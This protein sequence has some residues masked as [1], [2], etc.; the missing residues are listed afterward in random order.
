LFQPQKGNQRHVAMSPRGWEKAGKSRWRGRRSTGSGVR[1]WAL[2]KPGKGCSGQKRKAETGNQGPSGKRQGW[3]LAGKWYDRVWPGGGSGRIHSRRDVRL[4]PP[5]RTPEPRAGPGIQPFG[6]VERFG[7]IQLDWDMASRR[8]P[9]GETSAGTRRRGRR[10][11]GAGGKV[12]FWSLKNGFVLACLPG[13]EVGKSPVFK[14]LFHWENGFVL[15]KRE[16]HRR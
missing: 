11:H 5:A 14:G 7:R 2:Q 16:N 1:R 10:R 9:G 6:L 3:R 15:S 12:D 8:Q 4:N 13:A